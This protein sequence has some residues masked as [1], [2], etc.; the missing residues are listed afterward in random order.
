MSSIPPPGAAGHSPS[1]AGPAR[2]T[3]VRSTLR[4]FL[5]L[6]LAAWLVLFVGWLSLHWLILPHIEEWRPTIEA[7]A[8]AMLGAPIRIGAIRA[9]SSGWVP[10]LELRDVRVL[11]A[12]QRVALTLPRVFAA[13]SPRSLLALRAAPG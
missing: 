12:E 13:L 5:W 6:M 2:W 9:Q 11:D 8:S 4:A 1:S 3:P 10:A 7:R